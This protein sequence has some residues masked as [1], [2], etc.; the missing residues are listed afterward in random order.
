MRSRAPVWAQLLARKLLTALGETVLSHPTMSNHYSYPQEAIQPL[1]DMIEDVDGYMKR[2]W[3]F[4]YRRQAFW[5]DDN[6]R[7]V[8]EKAGLDDD[9]M[10]DICPLRSTL[11]Q[12]ELE[13]V[14]HWM[15]D[16][17]GKYKGCKPVPLTDPPTKNM[18]KALP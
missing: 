16:G 15:R 11:I 9:T 18:D 2:K 10:L 3:A 12:N 6:L 14:A 7:A 4:S 1:A 17:D 5:K 13:E 8:C